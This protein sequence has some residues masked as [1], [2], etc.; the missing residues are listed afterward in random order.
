MVALGLVGNGGV[1]IPGDY[2]R[3]IPPGLRKPGA[4]IIVE[5]ISEKGLRYEKQ[6]LFGMEKKQ[7]IP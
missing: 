6:H 5:Q 2:I 7:G 4:G 3:F 1:A